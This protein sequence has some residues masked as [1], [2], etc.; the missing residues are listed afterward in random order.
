MRQTVIGRI[1]SIDITRGIA[2]LG[3]FTMNATDMAYPQELILDFHAADPT[4]GW[5]YWVAFNFEV[6]FSGKMRGLFTLLFGVSSV[7]IAERII[8]KTDGLTATEYYFRRLLWLLVFGLVNAYI[9]LWWGDVLFK[10]ALLGLL[11]FYFRSASNRSLSVAIVTCL[12]VLTIQPY[13]E[14]R[15][16]AN[17]EQEYIAVQAKQLAAQPL[18]SEDYEF[19]DHWQAVLADMSPDDESIEDEIQAK[20]GS[21]AGIL[22]YN[23]TY[24]V[25]EQTSIF[26]TEDVWDMLLFM[27]LGIMLLRMGFFEEQFSRIVHLS[28]AVYGIGIGLAVHTGLNIGVYANYSD[29][30][31]SLYYLIFYDLGRVPF[32]IGYASLVILVFHQE[33]FKYIGDGMVAVGRMA[34]SNYLMQSIIGAFVFYGFGLARF[35]EMSRLDLAAFILLVWIFQMLFS[36]LW[37]RVFN[38]GP[39]EWLWRSLTYWEVQP[40]RIPPG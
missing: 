35:G 38:H 28:I 22:R 14:Y 19:V 7:L 30:V 39:V 13:M 23:A 16:T 12:A 2:V 21:Y 36:V 3:I 29:P 26:Y 27:F 25:E 20:S 8:Q 11:L 31:A 4:M 33:T 5:N 32:V 40:L 9:F 37:M 18:T 6:L 34:L 1:R 15:D 17:L 24:A 10:Y